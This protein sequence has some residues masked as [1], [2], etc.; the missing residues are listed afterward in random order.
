MS[1]PP[2]RLAEGS[3]QRLDVSQEQMFRWSGLKAGDAP[4]RVVGADQH[5]RRRCVPTTARLGLAGPLPADRLV[6]MNDKELEERQL[7]LETTL[8]ELIEHLREHSEHHW[9]DTLQ[10]IARGIADE[11][12]L[13]VDRLLTAF[14]GM[15]SLSDLVVSP[16]NG[17][18]VRESDV[19]AVN[20]RLARL[21]AA[22]WAEARA[23]R[24]ELRRR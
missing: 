2:E 19:E 1:E 13:S 8:S 3:L 9:A 17:H 15:G 6:S 16:A 11:S 5:R 23:I 10:L 4:V 20:E 22:T 24:T 21:R 14:G 12:A 18:T 7:R